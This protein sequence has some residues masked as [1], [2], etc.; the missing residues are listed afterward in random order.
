MILD[1]TPTTTGQQFS[2]QKYRG[3]TLEI[4][5]VLCECGG[6]T[7]H[8][9]AEKTGISPRVIYQYCL[10]G[11]RR[12]ILERKERWGWSASPLG[13]L[14]LS[15]TTTT[16]TT[17]NTKLTQSYHKA[18][19]KL[20]QAPRQL[21]LSTFTGREDMDETDKSVVGVLVSHYERTGIKFRHFG[22]HYEIASVMGIA[23]QDVIPTLRHL[24]DEG[25]LY[26]RRD[27]LG[28]KVGLKQDFIW[29]LENV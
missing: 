14:V 26:F 25:C 5:G 15:I 9:I 2:P 22:D 13:L 6:L 27:E 23:A 16:T 7:T 28:W 17:A 19:T 20:T 21:N 3:H 1:S 12:G 10:R 24:R 4:L 8:E 29:R 18:N 11:Y